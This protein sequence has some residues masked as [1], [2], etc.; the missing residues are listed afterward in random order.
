MQAQIILDS[1]LQSAVPY[2]TVGSRVV[3]VGTDHAYLPIFLVR[4]G[5]VARALAC[6]INQGPIDSARANIAAAGLAD[7]IDT[8]RTDGLHGVEDFHPDHVMIFGMGG[9]LIIRI[10]SEAPWVKNAG[11]GLILQPM[12]RAHLL[13]AWLLENGF[14]ITGETLT[15]EDKYYQTLS[16]RYSGET[17]TYSTEE[18]LLGRINIDANPPLLSGLVRHEIGV[19]EAILKGKSRSATADVRAEKEILSILKSRLEKIT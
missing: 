16:A 6:D 5:I 1:R 17:D 18:L 11:I 7:R 19:Y 13:R 15:Y 12:S 3:D 4:E 14:A 9:E 2:L 8:L 10:L